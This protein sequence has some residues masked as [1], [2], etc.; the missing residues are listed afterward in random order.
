MWPKGNKRVAEEGDGVEMGEKR[1]KTD[2][3]P[4]FKEP[5]PGVVVNLQSA[6]Q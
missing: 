2:Q 5:L 4:V 1:V 6:D 3:Q